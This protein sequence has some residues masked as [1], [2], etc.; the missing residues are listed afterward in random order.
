MT[1]SIHF[2]EKEGRKRGFEFDTIIYFTYDKKQFDNM[3]I[4]YYSKKLTK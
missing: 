1:H 4:T 3:I 2:K